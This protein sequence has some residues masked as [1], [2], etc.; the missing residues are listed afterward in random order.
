MTTSRFLFASLAVALASVSSHAAPPSD[1]AGKFVSLQDDRLEFISPNAGRDGNEVFEFVYDVLSSASSSIVITYASGTRRREVTLDFLP[2]GSPD[3]FAEMEFLTGG[4]PMPPLV[5]NGEFEI[6]NLE[7]DIKSSA[8][9]SL[10]GLYVKAGPDRYEFLTDSQGRLFVPGNASYFDYSYEI[11]D[12]VSARV[13]LV[14]GDSGETVRLL[15]VFDA[16]GVP[17]EAVTG[18]EEGE[19][20]VEFEL[21]V[22]RHVVDLQIGREGEPRIGDDFYNAVGAHQTIREKGSSRDL[23]VRSILLENDGETDSIGVR[24]TRGRRK[25]ALRYFAGP[26]RTNI[27]AEVV[28]GAYETGDLAHG[29]SREIFLEIEPGRGPGAIV[30]MVSGVSREVEDSGDRVKAMVLLKKSKGRGGKGK[31]SKSSKPGGK[32]KGKGQPPG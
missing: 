30:A 10:R 13:T 12:E 6:G 18:D 32:G 31:K 5:R 23:V 14:Y 17:V 19:S 22:N 26:E 2:D 29:E 4:P 24:G 7:T 15:L 28:A 21:G 11:V 16:E 25:M 3:G 1:L 20:V 27:T 9:E 8:P